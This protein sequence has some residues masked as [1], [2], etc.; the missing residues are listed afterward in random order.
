M[1]K[2]KEIFFKTAG[3]KALMLGLAICAL[4]SVPAFAEDKP[5]SRVQIDISPSED[6]ELESG[7]TYA[8]PEAVAMD[9]GYEV[10]GFSIDGKNQGSPKKPYTYTISV[11]AEGGNVFDD[12]TVVEVRGAYEMAVTEK[13][14]NSI[15]I[16]ANAYPFTILKEPTNFSQ[17]GSSIKWGKVEYASGYDVVIYYTTKNGDDKVAKKSVNGTHINVKSY[18]ENGKEF[19]H[20]AVR[21]KYDKKDDLAQYIADSQYVDPSG[22]VDGEYS[23]D[24]YIFNLI[25]LKAKGVS[26]GSFKEYSAKKKKKTAAEKAKENKK[27]P[28]S[29]YYS[30]TEDSNSS[31]GGP[32]STVLG[33]R[34]NGEDWYFEENGRLAKGW[35]QVNNNW[36]FFDEDGKMLTG[37]RKIGEQWYY[38]DQNAASAGAMLSGWAFLNNQWYYLEPKAE[39]QGKMLTGWQEINGQWYYFQ[40]EN[41]AML[42]GWQNIGDKWYF[43][44]I[45]KEGIPAG[46][47]LKDT[48]Q[49]GYTINAEGV[50]Q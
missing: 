40:E 17:E 44:N 14:K 22:D 24:G 8:K 11:K 33:W 3:K 30:N 31:S 49:D 43:L 46:A 50:R 38:L 28:S 39:G 1:L 10:S 47:M 15:K 36:Y 29:D 34:Q 16:K 26:K 6:L 13:S 23:D 37:W 25:T 5:V 48:V 41:G 4:W 21:A 19:D 2:R 20:I 12:N 7:K 45:N 35:K 32:S 18:S 9:S 27:R 42:N